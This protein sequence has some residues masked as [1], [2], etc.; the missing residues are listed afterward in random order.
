MSRQNKLH[1][2]RLY[3][4]YLHH[5]VKIIGNKTTW[6][7]QLEKVGKRLFGSKFVGVFT[8]DTIPSFLNDKHFLIANLDTSNQP[9]SHWIGIVKDKKRRLVYDS[10]GRKATTILSKVPNID[11][12]VNT[13]LDV[14]Q[15]IKEYNCGARCL[16]FLMVYYKHGFQYAKWI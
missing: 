2:E 5:I 3:K 9:G 16:A 10:F 13:E 4:I 7:T 14:E 1:A 8:S 12:Y 11:K 6:S 15:H